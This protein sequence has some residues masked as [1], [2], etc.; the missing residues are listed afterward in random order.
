MIN[1]RKLSPVTDI[2][3]LEKGIFTLPGL[4][5]C[6]SGDTFEMSLA[7]GVKEIYL[8]MK[9]KNGVVNTSDL[10]STLEILKLD[11]PSVLKTKCYNY[12]NLP[13]RR[14]VVKTEVGHLFEHILLEN[15]CLEKI[16][17]GS[18]RAVFTGHTDWNWKTDERGIFHI[19]IG[20]KDC[21]I[22]FVESAL[23]K[24]LLLTEKIMAK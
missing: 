20:M 18:R 3:I 23:E 7:Y 15:L 8:N 9:V 10:D 1:S 16:K 24:S 2:E 14:E 6:Y 19:Y 22:C 21:D 13:F 12:R 17:S 11:L 5:K 4:E